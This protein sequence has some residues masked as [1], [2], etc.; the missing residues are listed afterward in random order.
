MRI[1]ILAVVLMTIA[2]I[3]GVIITR[4]FFCKC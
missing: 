1:V 3:I 2:T 4:L